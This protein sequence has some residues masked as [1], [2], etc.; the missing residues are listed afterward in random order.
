MVG[1]FL[2]KVRALEELPFYVKRKYLPSWFVALILTLAAPASSCCSWLELPSGRTLSV[3]CNPK[4]QQTVPGRAAGD[5]R[6]RFG[7]TVLS[8]LIISLQF[9]KKVLP[10]GHLISDLWLRL[11]HW[12]K[13]SLCFSKNA[14]SSFSPACLPWEQ[15]EGGMLT[16]GLVPHALGQPCCAEEFP[17]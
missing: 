12:G 14:K 6:A 10:K 7:I 16:D 5:G 17:F 3:S 9:I 8:Q 15:L 2:N 4:V 1:I 13:K 11:G